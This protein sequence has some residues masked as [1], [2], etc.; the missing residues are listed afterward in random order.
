MSMNISRVLT[1][2]AE[3]R[4]GA[5]NE[6]KDKE[7]IEFLKV[8]ASKGVDINH[9][10]FKDFRP[11]NYEAITAMK[12]RI[13]AVGGEKK[14]EEVMIMYF[15][16]YIKKV[17][18]DWDT[19]FDYL[20]IGTALLNEPEG[21]KLHQVGFF[22]QQKAL[23]YLETNQETCPKDVYLCDEIYA[24]FEH[25]GL[26][27]GDPSLA[28]KVT[29]RLQERGA[30]Y[31]LG[32]AARRLK[33]KTSASLPA[34][35]AGVAAAYTKGKLDLEERNGAY[36]GFKVWNVF[37]NGNSINGVLIV[38]DPRE[39]AKAGLRV[40][41]G[42]SVS[43][44][45]LERD[46]DGKLQYQG[47][48][49]QQSSET[50][51]PLGTVVI[52]GRVHQ[53]RSDADRL[54]GMVLVFPDGTMKIID[55][56]KFDLTDITRNNNDRSVKLSLTAG[57]W[58]DQERFMEAVAK[59]RVTIISGVAFDPSGRVS[60]E[61][62]W[63]KGNGDSNRRFIFSFKDGKFGM[64]DTPS[65][66]TNEM[67]AI[68]YRL[69]EQ[70]GPLERIVMCDRGMWDSAAYYLNGEKQVIGPVTD[71]PSNRIFFYTK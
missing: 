49:A 40:D 31:V 24:E 22:M 33:E 32:A 71:D 26:L 7:M 46:F 35:E 39:G 13:A 69:Q 20:N 61:D 56:R 14:A 1:V 41:V 23:T 55:K 11:D 6:D 64:F 54:D 5:A 68:L 42:G 2:F 63:K 16:A 17:E 36:K 58:N 38:G 51:I 21:T 10:V 48:L 59:E 43:D 65:C 8:V 19:V 9:K 57:S 29:A 52:K 28:S 30:S 45:D 4:M 12:K 27:A 66:S 15:T 50:A 44:K 34:G 37:V 3:G 53:L 60:K 18:P 47:T 25:R 62:I 70:F 67:L